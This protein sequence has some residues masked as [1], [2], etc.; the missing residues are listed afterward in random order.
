MTKEDI[1]S[2]QIEMRYK[3]YESIEEFRKIC[4]DFFKDIFLYKTDVG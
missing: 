3:Y 2:Y 1:V 4:L